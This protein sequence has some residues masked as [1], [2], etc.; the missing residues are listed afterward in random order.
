MVTALVEATR[1]WENSSPPG[2]GRVGSW[3]KGPYRLE[4]VIEHVEV[5][6][7]GAGW[8]DVD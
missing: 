1:G 4:E 7:T 8:R 6:G 5:A 2:S 3:P